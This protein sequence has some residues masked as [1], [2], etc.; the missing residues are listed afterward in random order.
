MVK[1]IMYAI[2][3]EDENLWWNVELEGWVDE[4]ELEGD[5]LFPTFEMAQTFIET[6]VQETSAKVHKIEL[7]TANTYEHSPVH[8]PCDIQ[9]D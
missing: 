3:N 5:C 6:T 4:F 9:E 1:W 2:R 8:L 7:V